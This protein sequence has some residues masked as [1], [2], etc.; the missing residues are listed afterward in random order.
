MWIYKRSDG[1]LWVRFDE[2][3]KVK[4][5]FLPTGR[6]PE[7]YDELRQRGLPVDMS[8]FDR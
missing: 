6:V 1:E 8:I 7:F 3:G 4:G 5:E 2:N